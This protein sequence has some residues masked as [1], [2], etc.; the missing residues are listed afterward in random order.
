[1]EELASKA[2]MTIDEALGRRGRKKV[3]SRAKA[4]PKYA[5]PANASETWSGRGRKPKW[6]AEALSKGRTLEQLAIKKVA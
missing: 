4:E 5:N 6:V 3:G 2:G 1:M